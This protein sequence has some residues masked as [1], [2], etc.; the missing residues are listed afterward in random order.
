MR[1][2]TTWEGG[3]GK[4]GLHGSLVEDG[5]T[6]GHHTDHGPAVQQVGEAARHVGPEGHHQALQLRETEPE[7]NIRG[8][9]GEFFTFLR[10]LEFKSQGKR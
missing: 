7:E 9:L 10:R 5:V 3:R 4:D 1:G 6:D 2:E 8:L